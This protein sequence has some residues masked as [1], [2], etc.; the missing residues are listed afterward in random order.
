MESCPMNTTV[1]AVLDS[2]D[3]LSDSEQ[4]EV[5]IEVLRRTAHST[6]PEIAEDTLLALA[7]DLFRELDE[8]EAESARPTSR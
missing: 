2:F 6:T 1:Q 5:A 4:Y 8:R 7:D 3:A